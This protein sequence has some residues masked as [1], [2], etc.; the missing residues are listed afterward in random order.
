MRKALLLF[1]GFFL[2]AG[3]ALGQDYRYITPAELKIIFNSG[4]NLH[5]LD[6]QKKDDFL[7]KHI[8]GSYETYAYPVKTDEDK[9][10]L[11]NFIEKSK[12]DNLDILIVCPKG[13]G[14]A[15]NAYDYL[16]GR[17]I[18]EKRLYILEGGIQGFPYEEMCSSK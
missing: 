15:K 10:R 14:A 18:N 17:G 3:S 13:G 11:D 5:I 12:N 2:F 7:K 4:K 6:L 1:A 16:K 9:K 8:K